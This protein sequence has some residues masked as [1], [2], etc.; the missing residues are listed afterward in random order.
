VYF[1]KKKKKDC[2]I[3]HLLWD[4]YEIYLHTLLGEGGTA[5]NGVLSI[6]VHKGWVVISPFLG[7]LH[8]YKTRYRLLSISFEM[9]RNLQR[10]ATN[11]WPVTIDG[12]PKL[13]NWRTHISPPQP[14]ILQL[15]FRALFRK[16]PNQMGGSHQNITLSLFLFSINTS[17]NK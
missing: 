16:Y 8:P 5:W 12:S 17:K 7:Q 4:E 9:E 13:G 11:A 2:K 6:F 15:L 3:I 10:L 14:P 1:L